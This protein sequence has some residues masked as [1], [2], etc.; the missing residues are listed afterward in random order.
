MSMADW[1]RDKILRKKLAFQ[2]V[3][4]APGSDLSIAQQQ[5]MA[6]LRSFCKVEKSTAMVSMPTGRVDPIS[7]AML[8]GRRQVYMRIMKLTSLPEQ[9]MFQHMAGTDDE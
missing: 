7:M 9:M 4:G 5:V 6:D 8:E 1:V 2:A 3:F